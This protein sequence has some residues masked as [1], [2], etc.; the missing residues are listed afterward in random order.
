MMFDVWMMVLIILIAVVAALIGAMITFAIQSKKGTVQQLEN[1][2][3]KEQE[4]IAAKKELPKEDV[5]NFMEF[6]EIEDD[7]IIQE[8]GNRYVMI[9][10]CMGINYDLMSE[11]EMLAVE[12][13]FGNF[14]NT[15]KYPIQLYVQARSLDLD[16]G[17]SVYRKRLEALNTEYE[18]YADAVMK[19][20]ATGRATP[21]QKQQMEFELKKK[22]TLLDYG[23]D[24]V[25]YIERMS[26]NRNIL[27][28]KYY[29]VISYHSSELG[30]ATNFKKEEVRDLAY[31]ELYTRCR[32]IAA[33][34]AP[35]GVEATILKSE[36]LAELLYIAY[37]KDE[38]DT[39][40]LKRALDNGYYRLYST[41]QDVKAKKDAILQAKI[42]ENAVAEAEL[43]LQ[44]AIG[45][46]KY[47]TAEKMGLTEEEEIE[48]ET[49]RRAMQLILDNQD[50][51]EAAVVDEALTELN[52]KMHQ[53]V[54]DPDE[55]V[56]DMSE[57]VEAINTKEVQ[58]NENENDDED[59]ETATG[60]IYDSILE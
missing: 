22:R 25:K 45:N 37:N 3:K 8:N 15:L 6:D 14:L 52:N 11:T 33:A 20:K 44:T 46:I 54:I 39:Y 19:T 40:N 43:A 57:E 16:E 41:A 38:A 9:L 27:Q 18:K 35:C 5:K 13:G 7:M 50:Q 1:N 56:E 48:D 17:I 2:S 58:L 28:R 4:R 59:D 30:L 23:A 60:N 24:I 53:P 49:K 42:D 32:S 12:E 21:A 29:V 36:E 47:A 26:M 51:F 10:K 55:F 31:S 34:L